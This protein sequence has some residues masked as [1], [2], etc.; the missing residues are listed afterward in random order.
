MAYSKAADEKWPNNKG[1]DMG[2]R[3]YIKTLPEPGPTNNNLQQETPTKTHP[4][5]PPPLPDND[6]P[7]EHRPNN[8]LPNGTPPHEN[9]PSKT[10]LSKTPPHEKLNEPH[11]HCSGLSPEPHSESPPHDPFP[12][13]TH[14]PMRMTTWPTQ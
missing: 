14:Q 6:Q 7:N 12:P 2:V 4:T 5:S 1:P 8:H 3:F 10:P 11:T 13:T 9:P